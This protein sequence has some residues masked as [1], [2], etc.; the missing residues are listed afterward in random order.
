MKELVDQSFFSEI[1]FFRVV[2]NFMAQF[3]IS[4]IIRVLIL[5]LFISVGPY[6]AHRESHQSNSTNVSI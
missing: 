5:W 6:L 1:R 3:G 4:G 2:Q